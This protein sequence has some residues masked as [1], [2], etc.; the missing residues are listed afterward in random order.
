MSVTITKNFWNSDATQYDAI[1]KIVFTSPNIDSPA[2]AGTRSY[3]LPGSEYIGTWYESVAQMHR[4]MWNQDVP[5][6]QESYFHA[7]YVNQQEDF[8]FNTDDTLSIRTPWETEFVSG[9]TLSY[10][11]DQYCVIDATIS[12]GTVSFGGEVLGDPFADYP[13]DGPTCCDGTYIYRAKVGSKKIYRYDISENYWEEFAEAPSE[14]TVNASIAKEGN[15]LYCVKGSTNVFWKYYIVAESWSTL[16]IIPT[17]VDAYTSIKSFNSGSTFLFMKAGDGSGQTIYEYSVSLNE[18]NTFFTPSLAGYDQ[19]WYGPSL[20]LVSGIYYTWAC[21]RLS[22]SLNIR[23]VELD[24]G[25][26]STTAIGSPVAT[27]STGGGGVSDV[28]MYGS[29]FNDATATYSGTDVD[30]I[31]GH[32]Y[33]DMQPTETTG[34]TYALHYESGYDISGIKLMPASGTG[35][36]KCFDMDD[37]SFDQADNIKPDVASICSDGSYFYISERESTSS[38]TYMYRYNVLASGTSDY[39]TIDCTTTDSFLAGESEFL[40][41]CSNIFYKDDYLYNLEGQYSNSLWKCHSV[42]GTLENFNS[43]SDVSSSG[44]DRSFV[45]QPYACITSDSTDLYVLKGEGYEEF[46][47]YSVVSGT[48]TQLAD[49][50][51]IMSE[52]GSAV[53]VSS[54]TSIYVIQGKDS[55]ALWRYDIA[56]N[57]WYVRT[58]APSS[59]MDKC[60]MHY[61]I[62]GSDYIYAVR[63]QDSNSFWRYSTVSN[64]WSSLTN[65][66]TYDDL[67]CGLT[68]RG[69]GAVDGTL[70]VINS[71]AVYEYG[72]NLNTWSAVDGAISYSDSNKKFTSDGNSG[73]IFVMGS[74]GIKSFELDDLSEAGS[75]YA[76]DF[77]FS[78]VVGTS[79]VDTAE[80]FYSWKDNLQNT[81]VW[82][83]SQTSIIFEVTNG[84][85]YDC[86]LTAWDDETHTTTTNKI[87][88]DEH[89]K[90]VATAYKAY[91]GTTIAPQSDNGTDTMVHPAGIDIP[92]K[93][94]VKYFGDFDLIHIADGGITGSEHGEYLIFTPRLH[95]MDSTF[96]SGNYDFVTTLHYQYT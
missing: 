42:S 77:T 78:S 10:D 70:Y 52:Y 91:S 28:Y 53:Y 17:T 43:Y 46:Y 79:V 89:Y 54:V 57:T 3:I 48:W 76:Y 65:L 49:A 82:S 5:S 87:L 63:G 11:R 85:A 39:D 18:W 6:K 86:R 31:L 58:G 55:N 72:V 64:T 81:N 96:A 60:V 71:T 13:L 14:F 74:D 1:A 56:S 62:Y 66:I 84:E 12:G 35:Y 59:F 47:K 95:N 73:N 15:Y 4:I 20:F 38:G 67:A 8:N 37:L 9:Q 16:R 80:V 26:L 19:V 27:Y 90:V 83:N 29:Y 40:G 50:P 36:A 68:S 51:G 23:Y 32:F 45:N 93:G 41:T 88:D 44:T 33:I 92:L 34:F 21:T 94:N 2:S 24:V 75:Q 7:L 61:P 30:K 22:T 69:T 25:G